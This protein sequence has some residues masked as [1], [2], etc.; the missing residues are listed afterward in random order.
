MKVKLAPPPG[1][2][3]AQILPECDAMIARQIASPRPTPGVADSR[4]PRVNFLK[5]RFLPARGQARAVVG[6]RDMQHVADD[7]GR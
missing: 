5:H 4:S 2:L 6:D 7:I 1:R 3:L